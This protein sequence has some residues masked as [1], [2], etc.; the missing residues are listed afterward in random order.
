M[1]VG[2]GGV[3]L[4]QTSPIPRSP[5][6]DNNIQRNDAS[7]DD[8]NSLEKHS[9]STQV[10]LH[11]ISKGGNTDMLGE[12]IITIALKGQKNNV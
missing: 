6:G 12:P 3:G 11:I 8:A 5:D 4:S 7:L 2:W 9:R 10:H 1:A